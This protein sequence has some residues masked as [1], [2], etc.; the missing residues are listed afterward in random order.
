LSKMP[1]GT[2]MPVGQSFYTPAQLLQEVDQAT[3]VGRK[4]IEAELTHQEG[5]LQKS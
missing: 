1:A 3:P 5:V 2:K 4:L